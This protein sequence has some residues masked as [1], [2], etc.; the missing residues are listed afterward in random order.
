MVAL[1]NKIE[2]KKRLTRSKV[3]LI[4]NF[5]LVPVSMNVIYK[6]FNTL[7]T[8]A[9]IL[10]ESHISTYFIDNNITVNLYLSWNIF[11]ED[12]TARSIFPF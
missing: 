2:T 5:S 10:L 12:N 4:I 9:L 11:K 6:T 3:M 8:S 7:V 1:D